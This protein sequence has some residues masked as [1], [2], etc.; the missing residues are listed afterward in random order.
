MNPVR[1]A[2]ILAAVALNAFASLTAR[3]QDA[4]RPDT[5]IGD[6]QFNMPKGW[7]RKDTRDGPTLVPTDLAQGSVAYIGLLAKQPL[8][9]DLR[10][11]FSATWADWQ[12]QFRV[13]DATAPASGR[14]DDGFETMRIYSRISS[15]AF[16]FSVFVFGAARVGDQVNSYYFVSNAN[17]YSYL[18]DLESIER[19]LRFSNGQAAVVQRSAAADSLASGGPYRLYIG[20][21]MRGATPFEAT[22]FEYLVLFADGNA[23]RMLPFEGLEHFDLAAA[24]KDS[25]QYIGRYTASGDRVTIRWGDNTT[26]T[27]QRVGSPAADRPSPGPVGQGG[28]SL[29]IAGDSYFPVSSS[30]DLTL[31]GTYRREGQDLARYGI[32]FTPDGRFD[33]N[34]M[35]PLIA[36][37]LTDEKK[38]SQAPGRGTYHIGKNTLT[39]RYDD[40]RSVSLSF[41]VWPDEP[42][43]R[44]KAIHVETFRLVR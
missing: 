31:D 21:R 37:S 30:D 34:G 20:Y 16:G 32:T 29:K 8:K 44:P 43:S 2:Y 24:V 36:Y 11:W 18:N 4:W 5:R 13:V 40:G 27:A 25:R 23:A 3:A 39:L 17:R 41:F 10:S 9:T 6:F 12:R 22:H 7:V 1:N 38:I 35:L 15:P 33:E 28:A 42:G 14:T 19:S 26:E